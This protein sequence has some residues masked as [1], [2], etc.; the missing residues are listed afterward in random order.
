MC[1]C[2]RK[3]NGLWTKVLCGLLYYTWKSNDKKTCDTKTKREKQ[4]KD[5]D[6]KQ[7]TL[8]NNRER[9]KK[10]AK[11]N[12]DSKPLDWFSLNKL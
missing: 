12:F 6:P 2:V 4:F 10:E 3:Y 7:S 11:E 1:V 8:V 9:E 5:R